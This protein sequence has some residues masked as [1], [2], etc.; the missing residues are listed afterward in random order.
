MHVPLNGIIQLSGM[1]MSGSNVCNRRELKQHC[2]ENNTVELGRLRLWQNEKLSRGKVTAP[3]SISSVFMLFFPGMC[4]W[5]IN[6]E[7]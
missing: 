6:K 4:I 7:Y 2:N 5:H 3:H 1:C